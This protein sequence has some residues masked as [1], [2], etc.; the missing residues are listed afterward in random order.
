MTH[1]ATRE[2][3]ITACGDHYALHG[4]APLESAI[5]FAEECADQQEALHGPYNPAWQQPSDAADED[6]SYWEDDE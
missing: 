2:E 4:G 3:W 5:Y 1:P 6:M